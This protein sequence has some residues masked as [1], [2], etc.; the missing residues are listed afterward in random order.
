RAASEISTGALLQWGRRR[1]T[2]ESWTGRIHA[3]TFA[4]KLQ[5][6]RRRETTER[7]RRASATRAMR[8]LQWGRR[9]ETTERRGSSATRPRWGQLQWGRRRETTE[10]SNTRVA[11]I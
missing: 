8:V 9:R 10:R 6:G 7:A 4:I 5:W 11:I 2:T 3:P 1:E